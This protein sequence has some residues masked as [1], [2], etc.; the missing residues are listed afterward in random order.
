MG[1]ALGQGGGRM[2][3]TT[4]FCY[5]FSLYVHSSPLGKEVKQ[6]I[7]LTGRKKKTKTRTMRERGGENKEEIRRIK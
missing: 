7:N 5:L 2:L 3:G 4:N 1:Q 6:K